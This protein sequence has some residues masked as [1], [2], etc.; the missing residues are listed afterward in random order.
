MWIDGSLTWQWDVNKA[1][2]FSE[3]AIIKPTIA[4]DDGFATEGLA[5]RL[6]FAEAMIPAQTPM[7]EL[8]RHHL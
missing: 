6:V 5:S 7:R 3:Q 4:V 1:N 8:C 2:V